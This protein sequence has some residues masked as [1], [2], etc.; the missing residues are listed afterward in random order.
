MYDFKEAW[1]VR[2]AAIL[3]KL[4]NEGTGPA[5]ENSSAAENSSAQIISPAQLAAEIPPN[6][7]MGDLCFPMFSFAKILRK[8]PPQ[9][10]QTVAAELRNAGHSAEAAGPYVNVRL[11]RG[12][13][14][15]GII[16]ELSGSGTLDAGF[17][18]TLA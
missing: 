17:R 5:V 6:P 10:A 14:A 15:R 7:E 12:E 11:D 3:T 13:A 9:I 2:I 18:N 4:I 16:P 8:G 1:K